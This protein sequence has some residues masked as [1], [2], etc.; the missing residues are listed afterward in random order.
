MDM[1]NLLNYS[2]LLI[3]GKENI[4]TAPRSG[5]IQTGDISLGNILCTLK[6]ATQRTERLMW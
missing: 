1:F 4:D 3:Y 2:T 5:L 6:E